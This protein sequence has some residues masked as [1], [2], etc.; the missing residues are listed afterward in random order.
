MPQDLMP[1]L[2][3]LTSVDAGFTIHIVKF[4]LH[5][6]RYLRR[7][8]VILR[9]G[10]WLATEKPHT[11]DPASLDRIVTRKIALASGQGGIVQKIL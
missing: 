10:L 8:S 6:E 3:Y 4:L 2:Q 7:N 11:A 5:T 9:F 1:D